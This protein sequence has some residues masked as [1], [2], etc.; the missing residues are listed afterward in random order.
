M[1]E[2]KKKN[3]NP[4]LDLYRKRCAAFRKAQASA[5]RETVKAMAEAFI[6]VIREAVKVAVQEA[7]KAVA[8]PPKG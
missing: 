7:V 3:A 6:P 8:N 5:N 2:E 1:P 4:T